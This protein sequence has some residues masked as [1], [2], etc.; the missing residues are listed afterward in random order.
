MTNGTFDGGALAALPIDG[1]YWKV[2]AS[3]LH[4]ADEVALCMQLEGEIVKI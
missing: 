4:P 2:E 3:I 1:W